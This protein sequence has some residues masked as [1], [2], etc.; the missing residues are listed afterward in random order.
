MLFCFIKHFPIV[1]ML[2]LL[3]LCFS[4]CFKSK[5]NLNVNTQQLYMQ[6][7]LDPGEEKA[8]GGRRRR[9]KHE[10]QSEQIMEQGQL[11]R[12]VQAWQGASESAGEDGLIWFSQEYTF[13]VYTYNLDGEGVYSLWPRALSPFSAPILQWYSNF[14]PHCFVA[15]KLIDVCIHST[16]HC[17]SK[18]C[19]I[20]VIVLLLT[21]AELRQ[22]SRGV[23]ATSA[24]PSIMSSMSTIG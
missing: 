5:H 24:V 4:G 2:I 18:Y 13:P 11:E 7:E 9:V 16:A 12:Q 15:S 3:L 10:R 22:R 6:P 21:A 17:S 23:S 14:R 8:E 19:C 20:H 1:S